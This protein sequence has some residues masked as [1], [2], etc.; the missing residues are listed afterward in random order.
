MFIQYCA[1]AYSVW[2][3]ETCNSN[4]TAITN[5]RAWKDA[6]QIVLYGQMQEET[7]S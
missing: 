3:G 7:V 2:G 4:V 5:H 1:I 6:R